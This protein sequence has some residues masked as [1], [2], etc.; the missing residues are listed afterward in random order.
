[1]NAF[2]ILLWFFIVMLMISI[3]FIMKKMG[4]YMTGRDLFFVFVGM[5]AMSGFALIAVFY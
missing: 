4:T 3:P 5:I 2:M 1:M